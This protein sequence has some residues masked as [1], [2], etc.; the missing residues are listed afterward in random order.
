MMAAGSSL[1]DREKL[2]LLSSREYCGK[3]GAVNILDQATRLEVIPLF[4]HSWG[5]PRC[6]PRK[7]RELIKRIS[8]Q[9][10][11][12][13]ITLTCKTTRFVS[14]LAA[15]AEMKDAYAIL[16]RRI[17]RKYGKFEYA[18]IWELHK[19]GWPHLHI[20]S[21]GSYIPQ[22]WLSVQWERLNIG[23]VVH[24]SQVKNKRESAG[25][26]A[27][28]L[29]KGARRTWEA[30]SNMRL[31]Q[32]SAGF[33][34]G[35]NGEAVKKADPGGKLVRVEARV[36]EI[37]EYLMLDLGFMW[38]DDDDQGRVYLRAPPGGFR[39]VAKEPWQYKLLAQLIEAAD[40]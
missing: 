28:Y 1:S 25:Y 40:G 29:V 35:G 9:P 6:G 22:K 15:A 26:V 18:G 31:V 4:C 32:V 2:T 27:K 24:I 11:E 36:P 30:F 37:V 39:R 8:A 10:I 21:M 12:R 5:C 13:F 14:P 20:L 17:R 3:A 19:S 34:G 23:F 38:V 16:V 7:G 33:D